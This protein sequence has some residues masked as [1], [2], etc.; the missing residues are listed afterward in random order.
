MPSCVIKGHKQPLKY[1]I[2]LYTELQITTLTLPF[3]LSLNNNQRIRIHM[4]EEYFGLLT[5]HFLCFISELG[6][7][8]FP[9]SLQNFSAKIA[10]GEA[11]FRDSGSCSLKKLWFVLAKSR[12]N[13]SSI[14]FLKPFPHF[15]V[16]QRE[17]EHEP[18]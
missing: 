1:L 3:H 10:T 7:Y 9:Y 4:K 13:N 5:L 12:F 6:K 15:Q 2:K 18:R 17:I 11:S 14:G 8:Y 16:T